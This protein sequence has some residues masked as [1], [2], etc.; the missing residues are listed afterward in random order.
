MFGTSKKESSNT[1]SSSSSNG[2]S[3]SINSIVHGCVVEGTIRTENDFRM[4]GKL[5]GS[6]DCKGKVIIG[7][8]GFIDGDIKCANAVIEGRFDGTLVVAELL[9]VKET[10]QINGE[11]NTNKLNVQSGAVFNVSCVMGGQ[12]IKE[13]SPKTMEKKIVNA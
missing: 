10:A 1:T 9:N 4:D 2:T 7:P 3:K 11:I 5:K 6:L 8:K 13:F 12:K